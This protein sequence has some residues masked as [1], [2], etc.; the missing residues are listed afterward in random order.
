MG[1]DCHLRNPSHRDRSAGHAG[2][3]PTWHKTWVFTG[4]VVSGVLALLWLVLR[5][6]TKPSR[7]AYPC[8][9]A[10]LTTA[11]AAFG[12]P[13]VSMVIAARGRL[14]RML[15]TGRGI[16]VATG[17]LAVGAVVLALAAPDVSYHGVFMEPPAGYRAQVFLVN[18]ADGPIAGRFPGVDKLVSVMGGH[19]LKLHRSTVVSPT[20]GPDGLI[21]AEDVV[22][23]KVNS[24]W[25]ERGGTNTDVLRGV[26]RQIV[27]HP[28]GFTGE[29]VV[30]DNG[31]G[32]G[33][34]TRDNN[35]AEDITQSAQDVVNDFAAEGWHVSTMQWDTIR[36]WSVSE[37]A[38]GDMANGYVVSSTY[39]AETNLRE[40]YPKFQT[41]YGHYLSY[42]RG[43]WSTSTQSYDADRLDVINM[44][45]LKTHSIYGITASVKNHM[46]VVSTALASESHGA[47]ARG[48]LGSMLADVRCPDLTIM[49]ATWVMAR[50]GYGPSAS[51]AAATRRDQLVASRD[52]VALDMWAATNIMI[53]AILDNG[54]TY[55]SYHAKQD[56]ADPNSTFRY[57][58]DR[59]M[60]EM[61]LGGI[62]TTNDLD[63]IDVFTAQGVPDPIPT[64]SAWWL[65]VMLLVTLIAGTA[66]LR[67]GAACSSCRFG[68]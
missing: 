25:P 15:H 49:D 58:L 56:P 6:G 17:C 38:A 54:Y 18:H 44:P 36:S 68:S 27:E 5:T 22:L 67:G 16:V 63:S 12:V 55:D 35:N 45:V 61:L 64:V 8:Q 66:L 4:T 31:Q 1:R 39:D 33:S 28:D 37:Y 21:G 43:I 14:V 42:Q 53:P 29:V 52:P 62:D 57:Y 13:F 19:G 23:I 20:S 7:L 46:G 9:Q 60:N 59:S 24:Q 50:P 26:I 3:A 51:Y 32:L 65:V 2:N 47:V 10:A 41:A 34:L 30:A 48:G 11:A 40:S